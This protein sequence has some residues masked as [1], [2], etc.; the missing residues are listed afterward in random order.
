MM[1][2]VGVFVVGHTDFELNNICKD[3]YEF[4]I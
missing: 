1:Q 2:K 3:A 4:Q